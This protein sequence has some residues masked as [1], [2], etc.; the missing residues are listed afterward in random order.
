MTF[1]E[2]ERATG[3]R[4]PEKSQHSR[5]WW[6]NNPGNNVMTKVWLDAGFQT[7]EVDMK[8][9]KVVF[10]RSGDVHAEQA[11]VYPAG[12][13]EEVAEYEGA[14][15]RENPPTR[16]PAWGAMKGQFASARC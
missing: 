10:V 1:G 15:S 6:S 8:A 13:A 7:A 5:A 16:H 4:L 14:Q 11:V 3:V 12:M 9:R 2:I